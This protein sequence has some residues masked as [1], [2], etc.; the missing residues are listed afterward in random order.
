MG[1]NGKEHGEAIGE[2]VA[3]FRGRAYRTDERF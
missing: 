1:G 3:T 2:R